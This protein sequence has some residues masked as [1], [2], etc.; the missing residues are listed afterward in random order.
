[1]KRAAVVVLVFLSSFTALFG[2]DSS[3]FFHKPQ[4]DDAG[5]DMAGDADGQRIA[6]DMELG[7]LL[8][9]LGVEVQFLFQ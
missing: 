9:H 1:M 2:L 8:L 3:D 5:A 4:G 6:G 7:E